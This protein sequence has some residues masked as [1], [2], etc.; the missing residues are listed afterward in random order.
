[1]PFVHPLH[2]FLCIATLLVPP[3]PSFSLQSTSLLCVSTCP[4]FLSVTVII[5][6]KLHPFAFLLYRKPCLWL[7]R[8][9]ILT[10]WHIL[11]SPSSPFSS[12]W[13]RPCHHHPS[14]GSQLSSQWLLSFQFASW[15]IC[16]ASSQKLQLLHAALAC[17]RQKDSTDRTQAP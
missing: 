7:E 1:M 6:C 14:P 15:N 2:T 8:I 12:A 11:P 5:I 4:S 16:H 10:P 13:S 9:T 17:H 3:L